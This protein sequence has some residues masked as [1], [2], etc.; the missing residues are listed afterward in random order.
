M[1]P[2]DRNVRQLNQKRTVLYNSN[3]TPPFAILFFSSLQHM[4][5][6][7][8]IGVAVPLT[9]A[10]AARLDLYKSGALLAAALFVIGLTCIF[11][12]LR[13][14]FFGSGFL[15]FSAAN[16]ASLSACIIAA[17]I[18]GIPLVLGMIIFSGLL[19]LFLGTFIYRLRCFFPAELTGTMIFILGINLIPTALEN[20]LGSSALAEYGPEHLFVALA[21]FLVMIICTLFIKALKPYTV[22]VGIMFG[23]IVSA[24][25]GILDTSTFNDISGQ[26]LIALPVY[27][28]FSYSFDVRMIIPFAMISVATVIDNIGDFSASQSADNPNLRKADWKSIAGGI[29][30]NSLGNILSGFLGGPMLTTS[31]TNIGITSAG[32]IT[33]RRVGYVTGIM[34]IILSFFPGL[35]D[36]FALMPVPVLGAV[37]LYSGCYI[38]AGGFS[39][40]SGCV[41]DDKR[42]FSVFLSIFFAISTLVPDLYSFLP[43][44][45]AEILVSPMVMGMC[46]L[47]LATVAGHIGEKKTFVFESSVL[48]SDII[49]LNEEIENICRYRGAERG[50]VRKMQISLDSLFEGIYDV[51]P[52]ARLRITVKFDW[53]LLHICVESRECLFPEAF[54]TPGDKSAEDFE[55]CMMILNR[56]YDSVR[57]ENKDGKFF[58]EM[59]V[60]L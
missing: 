56:I 18:G 28:V 37:L 2:M 35:T 58:A 43:E 16:S 48:P 49:E 31:T 13:N 8:S 20:F 14:R 27:P 57:T 41:I 47:L 10:H 32:G 45:V 52:E 4:I 24:A 53:Y 22:L 60:E 19:S 6:L 34:L 51:M 50:L 7:F 38:M 15:C 9:I 3:Q 42:I 36:V 11:N 33:S 46:V 40:L 54:L 5:I 55:V 26:A 21:T 39:I 23:F 1:F 30:A 59:K 12:T 29:R 44:N 25:A 17:H